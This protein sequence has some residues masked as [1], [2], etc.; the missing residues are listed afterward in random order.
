M[1]MGVG[2]VRLALSIWDFY[3]S[4]KSIVDFYHQALTW[5]QQTTNFRLYSIIVTSLVGIMG[6]VYEIK[7]PEA[8]TWSR[9]FFAMITII[10]YEGYS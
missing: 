5:V 1:C 6:W 8:L 7:L 4:I 10:T 2:W 3:I 9:Y